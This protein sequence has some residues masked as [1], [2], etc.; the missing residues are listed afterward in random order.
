MGS[1]Y[2]NAWLLQLTSRNKLRCHVLPRRAHLI[3][4]TQQNGAQ[5]KT[6]VPACPTPSV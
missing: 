1:F 6:L 3:P 4:H 5:S 2:V